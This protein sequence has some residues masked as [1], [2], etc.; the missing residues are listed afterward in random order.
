MD[1]KGFLRTSY[2]YGPFG[3]GRHGQRAD[4]VAPL[5]DL[6]LALPEGLELAEEVVEQLD[7]RR[8]EGADDYLWV[9]TSV[10]WRLRQKAK[11]CCNTEK[12]LFLM[13]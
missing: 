8:D 10:K 6:P 12:I 3:S 2:V 4:V 7:P 13:D 9:D 11:K 1:K 5:Q